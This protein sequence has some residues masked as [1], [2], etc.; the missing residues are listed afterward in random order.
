MKADKITIERPV[1]PQPNTQSED[2]I[3]V[4]APTRKFTF[5]QPISQISTEITPDIAKKRKQTSPLKQSDRFITRTD[6]V[7]H[8]KRGMQMLEEAKTHLTKNEI[9]LLEQAIALVQH[10]LAHTQP[11]P[12][13]KEKF[14]TFTTSLNERLGRIEA[15][16]ASGSPTG[17]QA[18]LAESANRAN[19][20][21]TRSNTPMSYA[22]A[23]SYRGST[24][25]SDNDFVTVPSNR[26]NNGFTIVQYASRNQPKKA[27]SP[28]NFTNQRV[29]LIGSSNTEWQKDI[30]TTRDRLNETLKLKLNTQQPV[31]TSITKTAYSQNIVLIATQHFSAQNLINNTD[32][33]QPTFAYERIQKDVQWFKT[34][35]H[36]MAI[37]DFDTVTGMAKLQ[38]DIK[39]F[40]PKLRLA[41][42][43]R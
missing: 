9:F 6:S 7:R 41:T 3:A 28:R 27:A 11:E 20:G 34:M 15:T 33:I 8:M 1:I 36:E 31:I 39:M 2:E 16:L 43:P 40:N 17:S 25:S 22:T 37:S 10:A 14:A 30:K 32:V 13:L 29:I 18:S 4:S 19:R 21:N 42:L 38:K 26:T 5:H 24:T 12:S 35:V 23:A